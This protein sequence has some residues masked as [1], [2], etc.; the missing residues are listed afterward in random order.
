MTTPTPGS[1]AWLDLAR[2]APIDPDRP[3]IDP[4]HHLWPSVG[5]RPHYLLADL[6][7]DTGAGHN[8]VK[9]VF[10]ECRA[11]HRVDGPE[12]LKPVGETEL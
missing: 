6:W 2:E 9:T 3:I 10:V 12:H 1:P 5:G 7:A 8:I 11:H 4:H